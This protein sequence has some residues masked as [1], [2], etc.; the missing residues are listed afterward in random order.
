[1]AYPIV[2]GPYGLKALNEIGGLPYAGSTRMIPI[3]SGYST[4]LFYGDTVQL[5]GGTLIAGSYNCT[6]SPTSP[7]AGTIGVFVGCEYTNPGTNQRI[8]AQYWPASTVAQDAVAYVIDDPRV[9]FKVAVGTQGTSLANSGTSIGYFNETFVGTNVYPI[10]G[11]TGSTTTGDSAL[12]VTGGVVS[13]GTSGNTRLGA[14]AAPF[15]VVQLVPDTAVVVTATASTSGSSTTVTLTAANSAIQPGMQLI[16][17]TGTGS[18][19]GNYISVTNVNST[20]VTVNSAVTLAS[21]SQ[22]S[23]IGYPEALVTWNNTFH[24]YTNSA[25]V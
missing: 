3:A 17:V 14:A 15:R 24:S 2:A 21:G 11:N 8:R 23:F 9:V 16:C 12:L 7:I 22:V 10:T 18:L 25:G 1:M 6:S 5:S 4:S 20:T 19:A 13:S